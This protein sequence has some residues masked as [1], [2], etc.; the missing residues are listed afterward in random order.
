MAI[1]RAWLVVFGVACAGI[2]LVHLLFGQSSYIGGGAVNAT[3]DS[4][5]RFFNVLFTAFGI[6]FVWA[7][8][9]IRR[10]AIL[11]NLLGL[12]FLLGGFARLLAWADGGRPTWFYVAMI[13]VEIVVPIVHYVVVRLVTRDDESS[14]STGRARRSQ[15]EPHGSD[16]AP[17]S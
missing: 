6:A 12:L 4:D 1:F 14:M 5:L 10:H 11:I 9:D 2:G 13:P 16:R 8:R 17:S 15:S 7:A 3:M